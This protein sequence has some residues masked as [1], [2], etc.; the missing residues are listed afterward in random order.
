MD[1]ISTNY[2]FL[3]YLSSRNWSFILEKLSEHENSKDEKTAFYGL[4]PQNW[5]YRIRTNGSSLKL[6]YIQNPPRVL[7]LARLQ[8]IFSMVFLHVLPH[9]IPKTWETAL[10]FASTTNDAESRIPPTSH[11]SQDP[12]GL[13]VHLVQAI[14]LIH[15]E[16]IGSNLG[17]N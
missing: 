9:K 2:G 7:W 4:V 5:A 12:K 13:A 3:N 1:H 10:L 8:S 17:L 15:I 14:C 11:K 16:D 6:N